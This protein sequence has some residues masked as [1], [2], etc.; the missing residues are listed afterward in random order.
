M[1]NNDSEN[2]PL[3][4]GGSG[5]DSSFEYKMAKNHPEDCCCCIPLKVG[6]IV[7]NLITCIVVLAVLIVTFILFYDEYFDG[8]YVFVN[9]VII[10]CLGVTAFVFVLLYLCGEDNKVKRKN[11]AV[12]YLLV[13]IMFVVLSVWNI[14]YINELYPGNTVY[15]G[16]VS[17]PEDGSAPEDGI[18]WEIP[19]KFFVLLNFCNGCFMSGLFFLFWY[20]ALQYAKEV[21]SNSRNNQ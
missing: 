10:A 19:K 20:V 7:A 16:I 21:R 5:T 12:A 4:E 6:I 15:F 1:D 11:L 2:H 17:Q 3:L 13:L 14:I 18:Y 9:L 8:W